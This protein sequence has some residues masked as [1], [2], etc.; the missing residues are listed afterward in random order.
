MIILTN[1]I[2]EENWPLIKAWMLV[3]IACKATG[4]LSDELRLLGSAYGRFS[5]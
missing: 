2:N 5:I 3:K 1:I 4:L